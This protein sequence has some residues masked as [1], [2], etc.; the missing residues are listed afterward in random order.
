MTRRPYPEHPGPRCPTCEDSGTVPSSDPRFAAAP[1]P[2]CLGAP[3]R[4][5]DLSRGQR[6]RRRPGSPKA[7][8]PHE[9]LVARPPSPETGLVNVRDASAAVWFNADPEELLAE[10]QPVGPRPPTPGSRWRATFRPGYFVRVVKLTPGNTS[11]AFDRVTYS[12][13]QGG[14][15]RELFL[16][17]WPSEFEPALP[18]P[19]DLLQWRDRVETEHDEREQ[20]EQ[21]GKPSPGERSEPA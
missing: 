20:T 3:L 19:P 18:R 14:A 10:Y 5:C 7:K 21:V 13:E 11:P 9:L 8:R 15:L 1:C 16:D 6:L 12:E 17:E 2:D 4:P